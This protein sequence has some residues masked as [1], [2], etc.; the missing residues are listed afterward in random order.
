VKPNYLWT[1]PLCQ[2]L[3]V[4]TFVQNVVSERYENI[5]RRVL[6]GNKAYEQKLK[7]FEAKLGRERRKALLQSQDSSD[8]GIYF[9]I[10]YLCFPII[11]LCY[12]IVMLVV[13]LYYFI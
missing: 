6:D 7:D 12:P 1:E 3:T 4:A 10:I 9:Y 8:S 13:M 5:L 11:L 2:F